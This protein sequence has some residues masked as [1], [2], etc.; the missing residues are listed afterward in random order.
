MAVI[1]AFHLKR[2]V[3]SSVDFSA[4][5]SQLRFCA[6]PPSAADYVKEKKG[7]K[8]KFRDMEA[9]GSSQRLR[10]TTLRTGA[11]GGSYWGYI[12]RCALGAAGCIVTNGTSLSWP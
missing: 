4:S 5:D 12:D 9:M 10:H 8:C 1:A 2:L 6:T 3:L 11:T 7:C